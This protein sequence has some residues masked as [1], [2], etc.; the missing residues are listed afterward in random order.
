MPDDPQRLW[1]RLRGHIAETVKLAAPVVVT[2]AG[3]MVMAAVDIAML[4]RTHVDQVAFYGISVAPFVVIIVAG[5]G[6]LFG[7][8][9]ATS[10]A[11]G[12]DAPAECGAIWRRSLP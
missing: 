7:T 2:R 4:G 10:H 3:A 5:I 6:L 11:I 8:V 9:V 12:R 1:P